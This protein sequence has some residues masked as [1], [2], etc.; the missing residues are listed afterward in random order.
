MS[1]WRGAVPGRAG[2]AARVEGTA[3]PQSWSPPTVHSVPC[4]GGRCAGS[5][6]RP[7]PGQGTCPGHCKRGVGNWGPS[8]LG[9][10]PTQE[11]LQGV[12]HLPEHGWTKL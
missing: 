2:P 5:T 1:A 6:G 3:L 12:A 4:L 7:L 8:V 11:L 10:E 9:P